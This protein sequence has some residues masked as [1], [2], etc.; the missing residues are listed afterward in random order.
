MYFIKCALK[1]ISVSAG[2][3]TK[4]GRRVFFFLC[5]LKDNI[6]PTQESRL[7]RTRFFYP[8]DYFF[9]YFFFKNNELKKYDIIS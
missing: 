4:S 5:D 6:L 1:A 7:Y 8:R 9:I 2:P 3:F